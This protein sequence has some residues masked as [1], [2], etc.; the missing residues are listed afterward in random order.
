MVSFEP[1]L[2][3]EVEQARENGE[4]VAVTNCCVQKSKKPGC[5]ALEIVAGS[6]TTVVKSPK[7][8]KIAGDVRCVA[9]SVCGS[10]DV[11]TLEE[12]K[13]LREGQ[14]VNVTGKVKAI[15][16]GEQ[17]HVKSRGVMLTKA[18]FV[19]SDC[20]AVCRGV[21]W[22]DHIAD[23]HI[24]HTYKLIGVTIRFFNSAK[25][26]S[27]GE[28]ATIEEVD[29]IGEVVNEDVAD[30][31]GGVKMVKGEIVGV[32]GCDSYSSC[33]SCKAKVVEVTKVMGACTKCGMKVKM[34]SCARSVAAR[35][36]IEDQEGKEY[37]TTAF[38]EVVDDIVRGVE[39]DDVEEKLLCALV[40]KF[41]IT[42]RDTISSVTK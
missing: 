28:K 3:A 32:V 14:H 18:D 12:L 21:A 9:A 26:F 37:K 13:D 36:V 42:S 31:A 5:D 7:K 23:L 41:T 20:T 15:E 16:E 2:R 6:R 8:F 27:L 4:G 22:E 35:L 39:G 30:G 29:D 25:Y 24:D 19:I 34:G 11:L 17:V 1:R 38:N 33:R 40:M 10:R